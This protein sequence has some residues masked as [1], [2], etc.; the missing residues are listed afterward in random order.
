M[1][2]ETPEPMTQMPLFWSPLHCNRFEFG[3]GVDPG[4]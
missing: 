1:P 4:P 2:A 3:A